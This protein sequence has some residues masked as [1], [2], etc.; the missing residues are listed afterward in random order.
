M[1]T[2]ARTEPSV[3]KARRKPRVGEEDGLVDL[4][5]KP[6]P[7]NSTQKKSRRDKMK[8]TESAGAAKE[9]TSTLAIIVED[10]ASVQPSNGKKRK[11]EEP[12]KAA[13]EKDG[14]IRKRK[15]PK[16]ADVVRGKKEKD[17]VEKREMGQAGSGKTADV[18]SKG[19]EKR[20]EMAIEADEA[21][22]ESKKKRNGDKQKEEKSATV[23]NE[24][25]KSS[26]KAD[27]KDKK[28]K[29][30]LKALSLSPGPPAEEEWVGVQDAASS[31]DESVHL[32]GFSTDDDDSS[33]EEHGMD[34]EPAA[35]D[36]V[37][38]PTIAKDDAAVR[39]KLEK[40]KRQPVSFPSITY[41]F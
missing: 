10:S 29:K 9:L 24:A 2:T 39:R 15:K 38:L 31:D 18:I 28:M 40:A 19:T 32:H 13:S 37:K 4:A 30:A 34:D 17:D 8:A 22:L 1:S 33:D 12:V 5:D 23:D 7:L 25:S 11:K 20:V 16:N 35:L 14:E 3:K 36:L 21:I 6:D 26:T 27:G 41:S